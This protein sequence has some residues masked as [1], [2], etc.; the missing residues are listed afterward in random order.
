MSI[1]SLELRVWFSF[2]FENLIDAALMTSA[3][4]RRLQ[5]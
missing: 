5:P 1:V 4:E 3:V 2:G